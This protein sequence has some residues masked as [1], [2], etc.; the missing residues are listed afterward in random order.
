MWLAIVD[1]P[2]VKRVQYDKMFLA[3]VYYGSGK[4]DISEF[5]E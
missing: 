5:F 2:P 3:V 4:P 1:L